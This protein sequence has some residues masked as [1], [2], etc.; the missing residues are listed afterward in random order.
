MNVSQKVSLCVFAALLLVPSVTRANTVSF[1][2]TNQAGANTQID[3]SHTSSWTFNES[4]AFLLGGAR[5][6]MRDEQHTWEAP[7]NNLVLALHDGTGS[8]SVLA[9]LTITWTEFCGLKSDLYGDP[10]NQFGGND[11]HY[12]PFQ[13]TNSSLLS[14]TVTPYLTLA[15]HQYTVTL[16]SNKL[17]SGSHDYKIKGDASTFSFDP[18]VTEYVPTSVPA[19]STYAFAASALG[20]IALMRRRRSLR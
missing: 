6:I 14:G 8:G 4:V 3:V 13:F 5:L 10:C 20:A 19:P 18:P 17:D 15:N 12:L 16:T 9:S 11:D 2:L 7:D 1:I